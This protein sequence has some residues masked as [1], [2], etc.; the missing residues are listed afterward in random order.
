MLN[1]RPN[2]KEY[3]R[4]RGLD[5]E[6]SRVTKRRW[7]TLRM[8][9]PLLVVFGVGYCVRGSSVRD[10]RLGPSNTNGQWIV[11]NS[12]GVSGPLRS[13]C[14]KAFAFNES[15]L[16]TRV[17]L[18]PG[19]VEIGDYAFR[20]CCNLRQVSL[21]PALNKMGEG[22][23]THCG[24]LTTIEMPPLLRNIS[25]SLFCGCTSLEKVNIPECT[26]NIGEAAFSKCYALSEIQI[27]S[28]TLHIGNRAF[29]QCRCLQSVVIDE[30]VQ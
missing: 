18:L 25:P 19:V 15:R 28:N 22:A 29:N 23:F 9:L 14:V 13:E 3:R 27:P 2:T 30:G 7:R 8:A 5:V 10:E 11:D 24:A 16:V 6:K 17:S 12:G 1:S 26:T 4:V 21:S 20:H